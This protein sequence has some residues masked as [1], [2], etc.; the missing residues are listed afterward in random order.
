MDAIEALVRDLPGEAPHVRER[1]WR[2]PRFREVC[3]DY[4]DAKQALIQLQGQHPS[5]APRV[6]E[7]RQLVAELLSEATGLL[8]GK[9]T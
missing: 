4:R 9:P 8:A 5:D 7:Y 2:D 1:F 3:E 6:E